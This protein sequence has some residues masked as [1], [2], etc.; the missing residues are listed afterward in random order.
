MASTEALN[1][2]MPDEFQASYGGHWGVNA[3]TNG[4]NRKRNAKR[5]Q[6]ADQIGH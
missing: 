6:E 5:E 2:E 1:Q 4:V 3:S